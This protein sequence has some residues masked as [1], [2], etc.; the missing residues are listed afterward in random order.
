M[1]LLL[2]LFLGTFI[3]SATF[4]Y[5][6]FNELALDNVG[7]FDFGCYAGWLSGTLFVIY[8][9]INI[10]LASSIFVPFSPNAPVPQ[11]TSL[12]LNVD[13]PYK[14]TD[15]LSPP[16]YR[17][18]LLPLVNYMEP[19]GTGEN[20]PTIPSSVFNSSPDRV[21]KSPSTK[22]ISLTSLN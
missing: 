3:C 18:S 19:P 10:A 16:L 1:L 6:Y 13:E 20:S 21:F 7:Y 15:I 4:N 9:M 2:I 5:L 14:I 12:Q 11:S 17:S 22:K 8:G